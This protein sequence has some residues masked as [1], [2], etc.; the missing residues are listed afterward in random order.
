[1]NQVEFQDL[2]ANCVAVMRV[3][4][5]EAEKT[6]ALLAECS[7]EPLTFAQRFS[8]MSQAI[9]EHDAHLRYQGAKG[10]LLSVARLGYQSSN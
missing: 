1:M 6:T 2:H 5:A 3:Y 4:F 7:S 10:F 8:L 9:S